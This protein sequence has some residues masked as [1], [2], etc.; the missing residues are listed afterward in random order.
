M[1]PIQENILLKNYST[2]KIGGEAKFFCIVKNLED[3]QQAVA[4]AQKNGAKQLIIGGGSNMLFSDAGFD[5]LVIKIEYESMQ[6]QPEQDGKII[7]GCGAGISL[8]KL[9]NFATKNCLSGLEWAAGIPGTVGGA[10]RGNAGAY[11]GEMKNAIARVQAYD[12]QQDV[13]KEFL[14]KDCKFDYRNSLFKQE[15][16]LVVWDVEVALTKGNAMEIKDR[17]KEVLFKRKAKLPPLAVFPSNGSVFKNPVV[18]ADVVQEFETECQVKSRDDKVPAGW[19]IASAGLKGKRIGQAAVS[20]RQANFIVNL[21]N[22]KAS[23]VL[24][25]ISLIKQKVRT[26]FGVQL[27]EEIEIVL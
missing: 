15:S 17:I 27:E 11:G 2:I 7:V 20:D 16:H 25:L 19:L 10:V 3:L 18:K 26:Q 6:M 13:I 12:T 4:W 23:D 8:A 14:T 1:L 22:A 24:M 9:V 5:G 21:G